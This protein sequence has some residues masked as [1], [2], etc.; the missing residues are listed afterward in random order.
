MFTSD[1]I[2]FLIFDI[3]NGTCDEDC[4]LH[5]TIYWQNGY[6]R[7]VHNYVITNIKGYVLIKGHKYFCITQQFWVTGPVETVD[8]DTAQ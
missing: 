8:T 2:F 7:P 4:I 6:M 5:F 3:L 1:S